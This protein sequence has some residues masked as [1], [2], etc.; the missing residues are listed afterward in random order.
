MKAQT[1]STLSLPGSSKKKYSKLTDRL[2]KGLLAIP[3]YGLALFLVLLMFLPFAWMLGTSFKPIEETIRFPPT[4][5]PENPV[6]FENYA[7]V[8]QTIPFFGYVANS[9]TVSLTNTFAALFTSALAGYIFAKFIFKGRDGLFF[10]IVSTMMVPFQ[11][12][13]VPVFLI[14]RALH[15]YDS[16]WA[17]IVPGLV[18]AWGIFLMRQSMK[19]LPS[20]LLDAARIDGSSEMGIFLRIVLP[21]SMPTLSALGIF[22]FM[23]NWNDFLWPLIVI[24]KVTSRTLPLGLATFSQGF[25]ISRWNLVMAGVVL[26]ILP[27]LVVFVVLQRNFIEGITLGGVKG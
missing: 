13:L 21:L 22:V 7:K 15:L 5:I 8:F 17:L 4:F 16:L 19:S 12:V 27:I 6:W 20:E 3:R 9:L 2:I 18:S 24:S 26:S 23:H 10:L 11:V 25:G 1:T 14:I